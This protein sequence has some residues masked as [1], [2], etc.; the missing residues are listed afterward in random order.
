M[1]R[2]L[3]EQQK[4]IL[5]KAYENHTTVVREKEKQGKRVADLHTWEML[6]ACFGFN[7]LL[8][9]ITHTVAEGERIATGQKFRKS[10]DPRRYDS[11]MASLSRAVTRLE[12]RGLVWRPVGTYGHRLGIQPPGTS[13]KV[14]DV[15]AATLSQ[16]LSNVNTSELNK[17]WL[18]WHQAAGMILKRSL[19]QSPAYSSKA[20]DGLTGNAPY[21]DSY[22][23]KGETEWQSSQPS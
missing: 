16:L 19:E 10:I 15:P 3:S 7:D 11:A 12:Q 1:G 6:L 22:G 18:A 5:K 4:T 14:D 20:A 9:D 13:P 17:I 21:P 23:Q 8:V 2:G